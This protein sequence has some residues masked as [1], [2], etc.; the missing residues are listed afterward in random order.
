MSQQD[1]N[2]DNDPSSK[3]EVTLEQLAE[4]VERLRKEV[5]RLREQVNKIIYE[6]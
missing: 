1:H 5:A 6:L 2:E 4:E 3:P